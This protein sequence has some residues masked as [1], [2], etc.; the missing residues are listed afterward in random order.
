M[1]DNS[2]SDL[3][4]E[5]LKYYEQEGREKHKANVEAYFEA[6]RARSG[7][8]IAGNQATVGK[9]R[10]KLRAIEKLKTKSFWLKFLR[11]TLFVLFGAGII[12][13]IYAGNTQL[14]WLIGAGIAVS[15]ASILVIFLKLNKVI[16]HFDEKIAKKEGEA[17]VLLDTA[18]AEMAPLNA[19]FT[20]R[21]T[22]NL[23]EKTLPEIK[24]DEY[25]SPE[26]QR[27]LT[28]LYDYEPDNDDDKSVVDAISGK[29]EDKP[30]LYERY[31]VTEMRNETYHGYLTI[32]WR[33]T[34]RDSK[35]NLRTRTVTQ[36][37]H[38][39]VVKP[40]PY[41]YE[42]TFLSFGAQAAPDLSFTREGMHHEDKSERQI[43]R[44]IRKGEKKLQKRSEEALAR[45]ESFT[46][47]TNS[48]FDV[49]FGAVNRNHEVQFRMLFTPLAQNNMVDLM[50]TETGYGDDFDFYK[51]ER[52]NV[53]HSDHAQ[54]WRMDP[55]VSNY[56]SYDYEQIKTNF[57]SYNI[58]Y[59]KSVFFDFAPLLAIPA[60]QEPQVKSLEKPQEYKLNFTMQEYEC[61]VNR[62]PN[63]TLAPLGAKTRVVYNATGIAER[64]GVDT[65]RIKACA[66]DAIDRLDYV[67]MLGGD[68][69]M[70]PVPVHWV[71]YIPIERE[72]D[73][74]VMRDVGEAKPDVIATST[75]HGLRATVPSF[76]MKN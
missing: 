28:E 1:E 51:F 14:W 49:L 73:I 53:I 9:Y 19:L 50:R 13:A 57:I 54:S 60:Y 20:R 41:Y 10:E 35:G 36:T 65:V 74:E 5:P 70:H 4:Y 22:F 75:Y 66:Y 17:K 68:G 37:L 15:V 24:F 11:V 64:D 43:N 2:M 31:L 69:R 34:Y 58:E 56:L 46:A 47:M 27:E 44:L 71:E 8:D 76:S 55:D 25:F 29:F 38:A 33:E 62:L 39:T 48:E 21:D 6:L 18:Y 3:L 16:K 52:R 59:F 23:I 26:R 12:A 61:L 32:S 72:S 42:D 45:G 7:V 67:T 40:K 63:N 30:F